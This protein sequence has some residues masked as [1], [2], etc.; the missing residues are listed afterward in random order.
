MKL[1]CLA[2]LAIGILAVEARAQNA[3]TS[4]TQTDKLS[5]TIGVTMAKSLKSQGIQIDQNS[6]I[7][8]LKDELAGNKL[9]MSEEDL[10]ATLSGARA[11]IRQ[12]RLEAFS[13]IAEADKKIG[14]NFRAKNKLKHGVVTLADGLQYKILKAGNGKKPTEADTVECQY[15]GTLVDGTEFDS[16]YRLGKPVD[17][18]VSKLIPGW[19]E[20]LKLMP[21]GSKWQIVVPPQLAYGNRSAG[22]I[23]PNST[24]IF[25]LELDSIVATR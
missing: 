22:R 24:L 8:G 12:R 16:S 6:L 9:L 14:D 19:Q 1:K 20:A 7:R 25:D 4:N 17:F 18:K 21:V 11:E 15:R 13:R 3:T 2:V 23:G 10:T 5:Y